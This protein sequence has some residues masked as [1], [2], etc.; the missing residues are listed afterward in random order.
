MSG[1][2]LAGLETLVGRGRLRE[3]LRAVTPRILRIRI[4]P[5]RIVVV[6]RSGIHCI[7]NDTQEMALDA[8]EQVAGACERLL[9]SFSPLRTTRRTPSAL[10]GR[11]TASVAAIIGGESLTMNL[12]NE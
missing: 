4:V 10:T 9:R 6:R 12:I 2:F 7:Q 3:L 11:I 8:E 1:H 5:I